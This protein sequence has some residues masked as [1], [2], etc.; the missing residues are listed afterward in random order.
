MAQQN[1]IPFFDFE[2]TSDE[3]IGMKA[4]SSPSQSASSPTSSLLTD[5]NYLSLF[6]ARTSLFRPL[7]DEGD[8]VCCELLRDSGQRVLCRLTDPRLLDHANA[9]AKLY[10]NDD[11][12]C[13][14]GQRDLPRLQDFCRS[15]KREDMPVR[16]VHKRLAWLPDDEAIWI[17]LSRP[18]GL[19]ARICATH[20]NLERPPHPIFLHGR[21]QRPLP[22][23]VSSDDGYAALCRMLPP[24]SDADIKLLIGALLG[25]MIP[26]NANPSFSYP[27]LVITGDPG[28]GKSTLA[29][30]IK[31]LLDNEQAT[32]TTRPSKVED[33]WVQ[34]QYSHV[35]SF[36]NI[37]TV[38]DGL[39]DG[40]CA[41]TTNAAQT[42]RSLYTDSSL[43]ILRG[44][45]AIILNGIS[46]ALAQQDLLDRAIT[47]TLSR[48]TTF[49][50]DA[51]PTDAELPLVLGYLC[52]L[53][54][55][56][57]ANYATTTL[58][59]SVRLSLVAKIATAAEPFGCDEPFLDLLLRN[60][61]N[62]LTATREHDPVVDAIYDLM[63]GTREWRGTYKELLAAIGLMASVSTVTSAEWPKS[64]H[65]LSAFCREH[66]RLMRELHIEITPGPKHNNGRIVTLT[67]LPAFQYRKEQQ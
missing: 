32:T 12:S 57:L 43:N 45:C 33:L 3:R 60:Q 26:S 2:E 49:N 23:P 30:L 19:C 24:M 14:L 62:A 8:E 9:I 6:M 51:A 16:S 59:G 25:M 61:H 18:D 40:M 11:L 55:R 65:K 46:P 38:Y 17:H 27:I 15:R 22:E 4:A 54:V 63:G 41:L 58:T 21:T 29:K 35:L 5:P 53:M 1:V 28:A 34:S 10:S 66:T 50:P 36:D 20:W 44:H 64:A 67:R 52:D 39:S 56:A 42:R 31:T 7:G 47:I 48:S 37:R 13:Y